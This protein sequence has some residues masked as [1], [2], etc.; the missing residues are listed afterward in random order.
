VAGSLIASVGVSTGSAGESLAVASQAEE[1]GRALDRS[2]KPK[3]RR[4]DIGADRPFRCGRVFVPAVRGR[5]DLGRQKIGFAIRP[6][7]GRSR[8]SRGAIVFIEGGPGFAATNFDSI[9]PATAVFA[10][11]LRRY[12]L[13]AVDQRGTGLSSPL[14]CRALQRG[15][16]PVQRASAACARQLGPRY[17]GF[18]T[19]SSADDLEAVRR[20]LGLPKR[21]M[22]LYGDSYGT[23]LGQSYAARHGR[24]LRG[25]IL[26][27]AYPA[28]G[29]GP[30]F[31]TLYPA[32]R[33]AIRLACRRFPE[34]SGNALGRFDRVIRR[35]GAG[36]DFAANVIAYMMGD[37]ASY[38]PNGFRRLN[39]A[40]SSWLRG[41]GR[42][43]RELVDPGSP[44]DG[45]PRYFS[46]GMY[47]A[48]TCSDYAMPWNRADPIPERRRQ[49]RGAVAAFRP[50]D[51]FAPFSRRFWFNQ[52]VNNLKA[53]VTWPKR[54]GLM[55]RP[56][57]PG[58]KMPGRLDTLVL[59]GEFDSITSVK[60]ARRVTRF[61]PRG[62]LAIIRNRGH[63]S[64]LYFPFTSKATDRIRHF[65]RNVSS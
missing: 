34:C 39:T 3:L 41:H 55:G 65:V 38:A 50:R 6:R 43:L 54:T 17:Q 24:G 61:F 10:P 32:A 31:T 36:T 30:F 63:A 48:V 62:R 23:Y 13:I 60:E 14:N 37:A 59:A 51:F 11:F 5:P 26:S 25:L 29:A 33:K 40:I 44:G 7:S 58:R 56:I 49:F 4:C 46:T 47:Q 1:S 20:A 19:A 28:K 21:K 2:A 45:P 42:P 8:P 9:R 18:T 12:E 16:V 57:P 22:I 27:S 52:P 15:R 64:E 53:C 35:V